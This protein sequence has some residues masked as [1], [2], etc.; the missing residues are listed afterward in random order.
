MRLFL[1]SLMVVS[2]ICSAWAVRFRDPETL[3]QSSSTYEDCYRIIDDIDYDGDL[4]YITCEA[5]GPVWVEDTD[6]DGTPDMEHDIGNFSYW[7]ESIEFVDMN[8][9]GFKDIAVTVLVDENFYIFENDGAG[10]FTLE[11]YHAR[12]YKSDNAMYYD[13]NNDGIKD[14][15]I[16]GCGSA[17]FLTRSSVI[18]TFRVDMLPYVISGR[19]ERMFNDYSYLADFNNDGFMDVIGIHKWSDSLMWYEFDPTADTFVNGNFINNI[20]SRDV[21]RIADADNDGDTDVFFYDSGMQALYVLEND[22]NHDFTQRTTISDNLINLKHL[23]VEDL[24]NDGLV[25]VILHHGF[26]HLKIY[27]NSATG[28]SLSNEIELTANGLGVKDVNNDGAPDIVVEISYKEYLSLINTNGTFSYQNSILDGLTRV[29]SVEF[30]E[31]ND[32]QKMIID[33]G[34]Y[35]VEANNNNGDWI[36][37]NVPLF[38]G[39]NISSF[40][41]MDIDQNGQLDYAIA[42]EYYLENGDYADICRILVYVNNTFQ[43]ELYVSTESYN[44][45]DDLEFTDIDNDGDFDIACNVNVQFDRSVRIFEN[46]NGFVQNSHIA[47]DMQTYHQVF[48]DFDGDS[49]QDLIFSDVNGDIFAAINYGAFNFANPTMIVDNASRRFLYE[50]LDDDGLRDIITYNTWQDSALYVYLATSFDTFSSIPIVLA[51]PG[52]IEN[53]VLDDLDSDGNKDL[54]YSV[55]AGSRVEVHALLNHGVLSNWNDMFIAEVEAEYFFNFDMY[56][57]N[58]DGLNDIFWYSTGINSIDVLYNDSVIIPNTESDISVFTTQLHGN[59][60]NPFN[61]ETK[62][63]YS[64]ANS[65]NAELSIYNI[66]GQR[67]KTL[68]NDHVEAGEHSIIWNGKDNSDSDVST[69]VY[70]YRLKTA[71]GVQ[72]KKMLLLK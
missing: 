19:R 25:D 6:G 72:N 41:C 12:D 29:R 7:I 32:S 3:V 50:D 33:G 9:D 26:N 39:G 45:I 61:P 13:F 30:F 58:N 24:N 68:I 10:N 48:T 51:S 36:P 17:R 44:S 16:S 65:G 14:A 20:N 35:I 2:V 64:M 43:T 71:D 54:V 70:F 34:A 46:D 4:D 28:F 22:V 67:V 15:Y 18:D 40:D 59:Y 27:L 8:N 23:V 53:M 49:D 69:G 56:D 5:N 52:V 66:K 21:Y 57:L 60:P 11:T 42:E 31:H 37:E 55:Y 63:S 47:C 62:I 38:C 1:T